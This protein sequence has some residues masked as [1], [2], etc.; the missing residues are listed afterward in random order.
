MNAGQVGK[1]ART[2]ANHSPKEH[3][4]GNQHGIPPHDWRYYMPT[5]RLYRRQ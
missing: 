1:P 2:P 5:V 4:H 3:E